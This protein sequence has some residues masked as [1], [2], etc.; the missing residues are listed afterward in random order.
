VLAKASPKA[1]L[2]SFA[3]WDFYCSPSSVLAKPCLNPN[4]PGWLSGYL[5]RKSLA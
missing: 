1:E 2:G 3:G 4:L 5:Q